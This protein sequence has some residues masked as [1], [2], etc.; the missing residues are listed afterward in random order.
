MD[1][2]AAGRAVGG[3]AGCVVFEVYSTFK[4]D[5]DVVSEEDIVKAGNESGLSFGSS[6]ASKM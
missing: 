1:F 5:A 2:E 4:K 6:G 3:K